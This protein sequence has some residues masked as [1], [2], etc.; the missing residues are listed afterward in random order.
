MGRLD[1]DAARAARAEQGGEAPVVGFGGVD[2]VLPSE[3][4]FAFLE[5]LGRFAEAAKD[6]P[7]GDLEAASR[8]TPMLIEAVG[9]LFTSEQWEQFNGLRPSYNDLMELVNGLGKLYGLGEDLGES[10]GSDEGSSSTGE[11]P[12]PTSPDST[13]STSPE[14]ALDQTKIA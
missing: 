1:L 2:F 14:P 12:K 7:E 4:P 3:P 5:G 13:E 11:Q 8:T 9:C 10:Q 6:I